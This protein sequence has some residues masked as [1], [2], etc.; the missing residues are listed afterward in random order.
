VAVPEVA[1]VVVVVAISMEMRW[2]IM[3]L[4][5]GPEQG[6]V[7]RDRVIIRRRCSVKCRLDPME[8]RNLR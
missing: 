1:L 6:V 3:V 7:H 4:G 8:C 2:A 5:M